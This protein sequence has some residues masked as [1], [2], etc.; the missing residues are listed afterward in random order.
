MAH[1][2]KRYKLL[3]GIGVYGELG[4]MDCALRPAWE[5]HLYG[6]RTDSAYAV[7][8]KVARLSL[9]PLAAEATFLRRPRTLSAR[10]CRWKTG[11]ARAEIMAKFNRGVGLGD[12]TSVDL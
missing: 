7:W 12:R 5:G 8:G 1:G 3:D 9:A 11:M 4:K 2:E 6:G 10:Q